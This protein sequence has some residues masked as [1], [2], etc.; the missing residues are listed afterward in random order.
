MAKQAYI[1]IL[2]AY[3]LYSTVGPVLHFNSPNLFCCNTHPREQGTPP[4]PSTPPPLPGRPFLHYPGGLCIFF[5]C[6]GIGDTVRYSIQHRKLCRV[7]FISWSTRVPFFFF[8][9]NRK[10]EDIFFLFFLFFLSLSLTISLFGK[11]TWII[12]TLFILFFLPRANSTYSP[13]FGNWRP[14]ELL[15]TQ[16]SAIRP[17]PYTN[18]Q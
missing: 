1:S 2:C 12:P 11:V 4:S 14:K 18:K 17:F 13:L 9:W 3:C 6:S 7:L 10:K 15:S 5:Q 16:H 8:F